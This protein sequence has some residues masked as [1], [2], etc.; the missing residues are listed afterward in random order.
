MLHLIK[1]DSGFAIVRDG[2][3]AYS[4]VKPVPIVVLDLTVEDLESIAADADAIKLVETPA[5][6]ESGA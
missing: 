4:N 2:E 1:T 3:A 6:T 5:Q